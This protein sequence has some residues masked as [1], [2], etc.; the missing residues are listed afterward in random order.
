MIPRHVGRKILP[1]EHGPRTR[2]PTTSIL[3]YEN[4]TIDR[5]RWPV[6]VEGT[7]ILLWKNKTMMTTKK[8]LVWWNRST[9][10]WWLYT[11]GESKGPFPKEEY[12][13]CCCCLV[14]DADSLR[15]P[16]GNRGCDYPWRIPLRCMS[17]GRRGD[18]Y[19]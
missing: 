5:T 12:G 15:R 18:W 11:W 7:T 2:P 3:G 17:V 6:V 16:L 10:L 9:N 19:L 1:W 13:C 4:R 8:C 14:V